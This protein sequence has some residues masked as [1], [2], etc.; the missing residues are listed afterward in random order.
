MEN[1]GSFSSPRYQRVFA[2]SQQLSGRGAL[3]QYRGLIPLP[4][5]GQL[6]H[7][8]WTNW[9]QQL[10][11]SVALASDCLWV[12]VCDSCLCT[13]WQECV[14][15]RHC[16]DVLPLDINECEAGIH[17][18]GPEFECQN[19]QGSFRCIPKVKCGAGFIQDALGNC[20]GEQILIIHHALLWHLNSEMF[21]LTRTGGTYFRCILIWF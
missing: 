13:Y 4:E 2:G 8:L 18:C 11:R 7:W 3:Y 12:L 6:W 21:S 1:N 17:N 14:Q 15:W 9:Q 5:R 16:Y 10:Q 20:I 19:T